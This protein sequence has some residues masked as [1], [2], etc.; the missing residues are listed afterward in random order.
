MSKNK[1]FSDTSANRYSLALFELAS[2]SNS[3][4]KIEDNSHALLKL[5]SSSKDF[6]NLIKDIR[7][8]KCTSG[9]LSSSN[10]PISEDLKIKIAEMINE[11]KT[12]QEIK[13]YVSSRFGQ[14]SL[15]EP[16]LNNTTFILW[17]SQ[18]V[19]LL[20]AFLRE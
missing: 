15:Y 10:A 17:Y 20:L 18:F 1:G 4:S 2:E 7:C 12:D 19:F 3:L 5:I 14:D 16:E 8:P 9:S 13:D 6:N 11:N